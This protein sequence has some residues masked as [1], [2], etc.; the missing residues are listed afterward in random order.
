[1]IM[2]RRGS[3][4]AA[5]V[6]RAHEANAARDAARRQ[7]EARIEGALADYYQATAHA[8][9]IRAA[10]R[11]KAEEVLAGAERDAG[12]Q[13]AAAARAVRALRDLLGGIGETALL[14]GLSPVA[15]RELLSGRP[16]A[17]DAGPAT[18]PEGG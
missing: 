14:C 4:R 3:A 16:P 18:P 7:R 10:A 5:A 12:P 2:P 11:T 9:Q 13:D 1:M 8:E 15:V 6:R 17:P